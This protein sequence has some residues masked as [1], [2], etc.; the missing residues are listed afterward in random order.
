VNATTFGRLHERAVE[1]DVM[2]Q[3]LYLRGVQTASGQKNLL[4]I[5]T[6]TNR[7]YAFDLDESDPDPAAGVIWQRQLQSWRPLDN[8]VDIGCGSA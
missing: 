7:V 6:S 2:A 1:G 4:F 3:P 8:T 5:A